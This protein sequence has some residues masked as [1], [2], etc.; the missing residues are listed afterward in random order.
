M[1]SCAGEGRDRRRAIEP[2]LGLCRQMGRDPREIPLIR[3]ALKAWDGM[4]ARIGAE[5]GFTRCGILYLCETDE[6][7][8]AR[9]RWYEEMRSRGS[10]HPHDLWRGGG[11]APARRHA[12]NGR[13]RSTRTMT[14]APNPSSRFPPWRKARERRV[15]RSSPAAPCAGLRRRATYLRRRHRERARSVATPWCW[16]ARRLVAAFPVQTK[17]SAAAADCRQI[18]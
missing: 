4:N 10:S 8:E 15:R 6:Q 11:R 12:P 14:A 3:V 18:P 5:T 9:Q 17:H 7:V 1:S 13:A 16:R 2:E